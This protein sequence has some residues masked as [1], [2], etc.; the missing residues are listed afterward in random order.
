[1][2]PHDSSQEWMQCRLDEGEMLQVLH[3]SSVGKID[4]FVPL[5]A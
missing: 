1:M 2:L 3:C 5:F 4:V